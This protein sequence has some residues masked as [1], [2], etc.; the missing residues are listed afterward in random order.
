MFTGRRLAAG[1]AMRDRY[2]VSARTDNQ[3]ALIGNDVSL[4]SADSRRMA[5]EGAL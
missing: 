1:T 4:T 2:A 5:E 3:M